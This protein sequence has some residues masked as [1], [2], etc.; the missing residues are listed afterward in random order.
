[1]YKQLISLL[2][3]AAFATLA[4][5]AFA[6]YADEIPARMEEKLFFYAPDLAD[7]TV[8]D[9]EA[10]SIAFPENLSAEQRKQLYDIILPEMLIK[11]N[12][13]TGPEDFEDDFKPMTQEMEAR[14]APM[15]ARN[16]MSMENWYST[17]EVTPYAY[18]PAGVVV[19]KIVN[20]M[21][22]GGAHG[23][24]SVGYVNYDL[25]QSKV[26]TL[27]DYLKT[28]AGKDALRYELYR[29][30]KKE[31]GSSLFSTQK[32]FEIA[33]TYYL[34]PKGITFVYQQYEIGPYSA[35]MPKFTVTYGTLKSYEN[36]VMRRSTPTTATRKPVVKAKV[37]SK[38]AAKAKST[39]KAK[40]ASGKRK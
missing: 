39:S 35:G 22:T 8:T 2:K 33:N 31:L 40:N 27:D 1:M 12:A 37:G 21:Y 3:G 24:T 16:E 9:M 19:M 18:A 6:A 13:V 23:S 32:D 29:M 38:A 11:P 7:E 20:A 14:Y 30:A 34:G 15:Y 17:T 25:A 10:Y 36:G 5:S 4:V 26:I 28:K